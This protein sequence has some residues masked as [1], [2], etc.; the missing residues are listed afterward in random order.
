MGL[1]WWQLKEPALESTSACEYRFLSPTIHGLL[2]LIIVHLPYTNNRIS[3]EGF[4][5]NLISVESKIGTRSKDR[6]KMIQIALLLVILARVSQSNFDESMRARVTSRLKELGLEEGELSKGLEEHSRETRESKECPG[7]T[8]DLVTFKLQFTDGLEPD[9]LLVRQT[10]RNDVSRQTYGARM[11]GREWIIGM[12]L[13]RPYLNCLAWDSVEL[14]EAVKSSIV[15][16]SNLPYN[17][18]LPFEE[19][20]ATSLLGEVG[21]PKEVDDIVY[22]GKLKGG[23]FLEAGAHEFETNSDSLYWEVEHGWTG[24]LVE[25]HPL[26][27]SFGVTKCRKA[28]A[29]QTCLSTLSKPA[30]LFF[31][32]AG[33]VRNTTSREAMSGLVPKPNTEDDKEDTT[34]EMQCMPLYTILLAMGNPTVHYFS[35]DIEGAEFPVL[36]TIPW[37]KVDIRVLSVETHLAGRIYPGDRKDLIAYMEK[38]GYRHIHWAHRTTNPNR[39][40]MGTT[41]DLFVRNDVPLVKEEG[42]DGEEEDLKEENINANANAK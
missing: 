18:T 33:S 4:V 2:I 16:P 1:H 19:L 7:I 30:T 41:D 17:F 6:E 8:E 35:P 11:F 13:V 25:P 3:F 14:V 31:D 20:P 9:S 24:L 22:G 29:L 37:D 40:E 36:K 10:V 15:P 28:S 34:F 42:W 32:P 21:Q 27:F 23:F 26:S 38:V 12:A 39:S 5:L